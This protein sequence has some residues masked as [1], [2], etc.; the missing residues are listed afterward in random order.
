MSSSDVTCRDCGGTGHFAC[1]KLQRYGL[2]YA[3]A[4]LSRAID[5]D[6]QRQQSALGQQR[7]PTILQQVA[8]GQQAA[9]GQLG[10]AETLAAQNCQAYAGLA[11]SQQSRALGIQRSMAMQDDNARLRARVAELEA[12]TANQA[13][14]IAEQGAELQEPEIPPAFRRVTLLEEDLKRKRE[15][16]ERLEKQCARLSIE[17]GDARDALAD[18]TTKYARL[19]RELRGRK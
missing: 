7:P 18:E 9:Q 10:S 16:C 12:Q 14:T 17:L 13:R 19:R 8:L 2:D 1:A 5:A 11:Q 6:V 15:E 4:A 3:G